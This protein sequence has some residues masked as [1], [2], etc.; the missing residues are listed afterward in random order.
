MKLRILLAACLI[1]PLTLGAGYPQQA[2]DPLASIVPEH[3]PEFSGPPGIANL[4]IQRDEGF[5]S[6][7]K[8]LRTP[9]A[10]DPLRVYFGG[11]SMAGYPGLQMEEAFPEDMPVEIRSEAV[12]SSGLITPWFYDWPQSLADVLVD[13]DADVV[14][15]SMGG[16]DNQGFEGIAFNSPGWTYEYRKRLIELADVAAADDRIVIWVGMPPM[17]DPELNAAMPILNEVSS[18]ALGDR[19]SSDYVDAWSIMATPDGQFTELVEAN[20]IAVDARAGDGVHYTFDG[21]SL[22]ADEVVAI[23]MDAINPP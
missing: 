23:V 9:T 19:R 13:F 20:G 18:A 1:A 17:R 10:E 12:I 2:S 3:A 21:A 16:N 22:V 11:D 14:V 6:P 5:G 4:D 15:L 8:R 7:A